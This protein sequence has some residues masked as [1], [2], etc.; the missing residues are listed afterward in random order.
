MTKFVSTMVLAATSV[1]VVAFA[2]A[3][4]S[5]VPGPEPTTPQPAIAAEPASPTERSTDALS[6]A[7]QNAA[8]LPPGRYAAVTKKVCTEC[9]NAKTFLDLRFSK[10]D[11]TR[12]YR[13]M[14]G[15]DV[16]SEQAKQVID[17]LSTT[18]GSR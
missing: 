8:P 4:C 14:V 10:E 16:N 1:L 13:N 15:G 7:D 5:Q 18:L 11:A 2:G 17:Y 9:H 3:A 12:Y 6:A